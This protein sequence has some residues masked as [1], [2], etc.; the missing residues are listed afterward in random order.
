M[1]KALSKIVAISV[2]LVVV[3]LGVFGAYL[4]LTRFCE[5]TC[6]Q[7]AASQ[8]SLTVLSDTSGAGLKGVQVTG[9]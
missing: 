7:S 3:I 9:M 5:S 1:D 6:I 8:I 2:V 4:A